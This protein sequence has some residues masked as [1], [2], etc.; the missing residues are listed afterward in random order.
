MQTGP[1]RRILQCC[2]GSKLEEVCKALVEAD[3]LRIHVPM[4]WTRLSTTGV[5]KVIESLLLRKVNI[6]VITYL[7][8]MLISSHTIQE[9]HMS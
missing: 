5:Y 6:R 8:D 1:E 9:A 2:I 4:F 7:D 3:S